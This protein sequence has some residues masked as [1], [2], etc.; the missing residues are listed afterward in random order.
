MI[1]KTSLNLLII[2]YIS[3]NFNKQNSD[4]QK[5]FDFIAHAIIMPW[6]TL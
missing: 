4:E 3:N 6:K 2:K 5:W 1:F